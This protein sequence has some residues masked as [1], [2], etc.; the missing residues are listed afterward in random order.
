M[1][2][3]D[4]NSVVALARAVPRGGEV[5]DNDPGWIYAINVQGM[6]SGSADH[7][8]IE[9]L[10]AAGCRLTTWVDDPDDRGPG[11][12]WA[13]VWTFPPIVVNTQIIQQDFY[14]DD[15]TRFVPPTVNVV[16]GIWVSDDQDGA[17]ELARKPRGWRGWIDVN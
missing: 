9:H 8:H 13:K 12:H 16:N 17:H 6:V 2:S 7:Y 1:D 11:E 10:G 14:G 15:Y 3:A 5:I 4:W